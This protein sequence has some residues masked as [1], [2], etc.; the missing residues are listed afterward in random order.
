VEN[1][2][3]DLARY[4]GFLAREGV[5]DPRAADGSTILRYLARL[6]QEGL[7]ARSAARHLSAVRG[8]YRF[9]VGEGKLAESPALLVESPRLGRKLP[10]VLSRD[11]V[12]RLI[13]APDISTPLGLRDRTMLE[14]LYATGLRVSELVGLRGS[15]VDLV[16]GYL[17]TRGKGSKERIVPMGEVASS[18]IDRYLKI[19]RRTI[20]KR[21]QSPYLFL[22]ARGGP[23]TTARFFQI[24]RTV[25][26]K[27]DIRKVIGPHTLRHSFATHL[28][29]GG[30]DLRSVQ[31][32]L[33]HADIS[34]TQIYT[35]VSR[36][37]LRE[38]VKRHH[39]RG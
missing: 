16:V 1:Y 10:Q 20:L 18:W 28:L 31:M 9:L 34:T 30:A 25:A 11:E 29:E 26:A 39:P 12:E 24:V 21:R 7:A 37:R 33:G 5:S 8:F 27:A 6:R 22:T 2:S 38:L 14:V 36:E 19:A 15:Q 13:A 3:L 4:A 17:R 23:M 35:H 32:M